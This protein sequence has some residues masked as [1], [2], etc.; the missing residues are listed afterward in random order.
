MRDNEEC[1]HD[2]GGVKLMPLHFGGHA[3][4]VRK[5]L[6][7]D[8]FNGDEATRAI[9][10]IVVRDRIGDASQWVE[11]LAVGPNVGGRCSADHAR[12]LRPEWV[13][14]YGV[15]GARRSNVPRDIVGHIA[16]IPVNDDPRMWQSPMS[17]AEM[18][19]EESLPL[20]IMPQETKD[21][22]VHAQI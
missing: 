7:T 5:C 19:I 10:G 17:K 4:Y 16:Y 21:E 12:R 22:E 3:F 18:F 6:S 13:E 11:I 2:Y 9:G 14:K 1:W 20:A 15:N 8:A